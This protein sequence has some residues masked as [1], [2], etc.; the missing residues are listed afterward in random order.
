MK[1][2]QLLTDKAIKNAEP[3]VKGYRLSDGDG[4]YLVVQANGGKLWRW[5]YEFNGKEKLFSYG[6]YP[7]VPLT[8]A[9]D[10]HGD[11]RALKRNGVDPAAEKQAR[12]NAQLESDRVSSMPTFAELTAEWLGTWSAEKSERY[13]ATVKTRLIP[14]SYRIEREERSEDDLRSKK[15]DK[16]S[17]PG[18]SAPPIIDA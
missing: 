9:R 12:I 15:R 4:L 13:V 7:S 18:I 5:S 3:K 10:L 1:I 11:A 6:P 16:A 14:P 8:L 2:I 17:F